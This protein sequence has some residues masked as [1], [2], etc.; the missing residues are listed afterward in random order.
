MKKYEDFISIGKENFT[1]DLFKELD[2]YLLE[3]DKLYAE[4]NPILTDG[5][6]DHLLL[7]AQSLEEDF[8]TVQSLSGVSEF[9][10][11]D[12]EHKYPMLSLAK[13]KSIDELSNF[14]DKFSND[15]ND[16]WYTDGFIVQHKE[17]GLTVVIDYTD[18]VLTLATRGDGKHGVDITDNLKSLLSNVKFNRNMTIRAEA[19]ID[20]DMFE[21]INI[22]GKYQNS[23]NLV[24][25]TI[26]QK[27]Q[28]ISKERGVK[29]HAYTIENALELGLKTELDALEY[30]SILMPNITKPLCPISKLEAN[31]GVN[32]IK[33]LALL[34]KDEVIDLVKNFTPEMRNTIGHEIDGLVIKPNYTVNREKIG[35]TNHHPRNQIAFK[36]DS[37]NAITTLREVRWQVGASGQYTPVGVFD[38]VN[39]G[40]ATINQASLANMNNIKERELRLGDTILVQRS[41]DVIPQIVKP[42]YDDANQ[43]QSL[44]QEITV[45]EDAYI[46][47][48]LVFSKH[49]TLEQKINKLVKLAS[50]KSLDIRGL[51]KSTIERL[52]E[53]RIIDIDDPSS[54]YTM[55][56]D[57]FIK[58]EGLGEKSWNNLQS[59]LS[60][61]KDAGLA[62][63]LAGLSIDMLGTTLSDAIASRVDSFHT[64]Y[65]NK[66][67]LASL[68][69][70]GLGPKKQASLEENLFSTNMVSLLHKLEDVGV[71]LV[72]KSAND[73]LIRDLDGLN[74][75]IT[76]KLSKSRNEFKALI[77]GRGGKVTGSVTNNTDYLIQNELSASSKSKKANE[78]NIP[79]ITEDEFNRKFQQ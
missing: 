32:D 41:N 22:D 46:V 34:T 64:L 38:P 59:Q 39:I 5:Q 58:V 78:L 3:Q 29:L 23:R 48:G 75:V 7:L 45:P 66:D 24:A 37:P 21:K 11:G 67:N 26:M 31:L 33:T 2:Q 79:V 50:K 74:F 54:L 70:E 1:L 20:L 10:Q 55:D 69:I 73:K 16:L 76:G 35:Y 12:V 77:E 65:Q 9:K 61:S 49:E 47:G 52:Y 40:G 62:K 72:S 25:G 51:S 44:T 36:F 57:K 42:V 71:S 27:D 60:K 18:G 56:K 6:Y 63:V 53:H 8:G 43:R 19:I 68:G 28:H 14:L 17:D 30:L 4:G 15:P 13:T